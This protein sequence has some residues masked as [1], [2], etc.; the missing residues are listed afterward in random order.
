M[1]GLI[2]WGWKQYVSLSGPGN[3]AISVVWGVVAGLA[4]LCLWIL[5]L[6]PFLKPNP[7]PWKP[8]AFYLRLIAASLLVPVFEEL[9]MR[10]Y[11]FRVAYQWAIERRTKAENALG[12]VLA[13]RSINDFVPGAWNL[14]AV[15]ISSIVFAMGH[16]MKEWPAAILYG[17]LMSLLWILRK[18]SDFL[19]RGPW[20]YQFGPRDLRVSHTKMGILVNKRSEPV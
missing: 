8:S 19:C 13:E 12:K 5:M 18:G 17:L 4:G 2:G 7:T 1:A 16:H 20:D 15:V 14:W 3:V 6:E 11:V 9:L 10:G